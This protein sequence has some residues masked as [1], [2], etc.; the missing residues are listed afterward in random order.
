MIKKAN[1]MERDILMLE[2]ES[3]I[4]FFWK[5]NR[6]GFPYRDFIKREL[7]IESVYMSMYPKKQKKK[8]KY[9][10]KNYRLCSHDFTS[11]FKAGFALCMNPRSIPCKV[12]N[13]R[14]SGVAARRR[15]KLQQL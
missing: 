14:C 11:S 7:G 8:T 15:K 10:P 12:L 9:T 4:F 6:R 5:R 1:T 2:V 3:T 13:S